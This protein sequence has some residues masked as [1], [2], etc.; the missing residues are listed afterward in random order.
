MMLLPPKHSS[1]STCL[2]DHA[3]KSQFHFDSVPGLF[4]LEKRLLCMMMTCLVDSNV[5]AFPLA[6]LL[7]WRRG[8]ATAL[9]E[10]RV[11]SKNDVFEQARGLSDRFCCR[12][13]ELPLTLSSVKIH[14]FSLLLHVMM[15]SN[16][17]Q[18]QQQHRTTTKK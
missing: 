5:A 17:K 6:L 1:C 14:L 15:F 3:Y 7:S 12:E 18:Q 16:R 4:M 8:G 9:P 2:L 11:G 13:T 10:Y